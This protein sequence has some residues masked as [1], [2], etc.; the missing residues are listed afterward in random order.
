MDL[1]ER[2]RERRAEIE[3]ATLARVH[4]VSD[5]AE[6]EDPEYVLGLREAV[7]A[8]FGYAIA[9]IDAG[10]GRRP[11]IPTQLFGQARAAARNG[12]S[13]E[14]VLRRYFAGCSLLSDFIVREAAV[15]G[16]SAEELQK[17]LWSVSALLDNLVVVVA[18]E[19]SHELERL[20][21]LRDPQRRR[22]EQVRKLLAG[23]P[24]GTT[25]LRYELNGWHLAMI[26]SGPGAEGVIRDLASAV[27]CSHLIVSPEEGTV[28]AWLGGRCRVSTPEV[29]RLAMQRLTPKAWIALGEPGNGVEGWRLSHRQAKAAAL[30]ARRGLERNVRYAD[31]ALLSSALR[32]DVLARSLREI[33]LVPL[34]EERDGGETLRGTLATYLE[35]GRNVSSAAARLGIARQTVS[36]RLRAAEE[37]IDRSLDSC[38]AEVEV[39]LQLGRLTEL[40]KSTDG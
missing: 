2:L 22:T 10:E 18:D 17:L 26:A 40:G 8:A 9:G 6:I 20:Q 13:L 34:E 39:A 21:P 23:E 30:V 32:D 3:Q 14:T 33:Y 5:P 27:D 4:A 19:Y 36:V 35:V 37:R 7:A 15:G 28:W 24:L 29:Q 1:A 31:V 11:P 12:V 25:D 38:A 16:I